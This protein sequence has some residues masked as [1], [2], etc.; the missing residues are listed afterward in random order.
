MTRLISILIIVAVIFV[1]YRLYVYWE[2]VAQGKNPQEEQAGKQTVDPHSLSGMPAELEV[3]WEQAAQRGANA[4]SNWL[5]MYDGQ[6]A[7][8]RLAW[9]QL[10]YC[11]KLAWSNPSEAKRVF[12]TVRDRTTTNSPVY[13]RIRQLANTF[14]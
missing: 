7:D 11:E 3:A 5:S 13:P 10:D 6:V 14:K 2:K 8:P 9:I 12:A 1:G 4:M